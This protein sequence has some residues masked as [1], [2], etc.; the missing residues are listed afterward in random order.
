M[1]KTK[2]EEQNMAICVKRYKFLQR[3]GEFKRRQLR[4]IWHLDWSGFILL[5]DMMSTRVAIYE[6]K[7]DETDDYVIG[8]I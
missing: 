1:L 7:D 2:T 3:Y 8:V 6:D 5:L 4:K